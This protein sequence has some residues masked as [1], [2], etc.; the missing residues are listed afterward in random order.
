MLPQNFSGLTPQQ[1][2]DIIHEF[3]NL[4]KFKIIESRFLFQGKNNRLIIEKDLIE[5]EDLI[6][7][8]YIIFYE[9]ITLI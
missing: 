8:K 5:M 4:I 1:K 2:R 6:S 7:S 3:Q 9:V